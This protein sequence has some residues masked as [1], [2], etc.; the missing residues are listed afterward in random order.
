M[1]SPNGEYMPRNYD[2]E[3]AGLPMLPAEYANSTTIT[4]QEKFRFNEWLKK[5][6][7]KICATNPAWLTDKDWVL[8]KEEDK[9][10]RAVELLR[11]NYEK[12]LYDKRVSDPHLDELWTVGG[13]QLLTAMFLRAGEVLS[14]DH[15]QMRDLWRGGSYGEGQSLNRISGKEF[16]I[17]LGIAKNMLE[18]SARKRPCIFRIP[19]ETAVNGFR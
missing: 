14:V 16:S 9:V 10:L 2:Q 18:L 3:Y 17:H 6:G 7:V 12:G 13:G 5:E 15:P 4:F 1:E 11:R 8:H 19:I